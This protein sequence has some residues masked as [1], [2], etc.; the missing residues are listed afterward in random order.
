[1]SVIS[2]KDTLALLPTGGGKSICFQVPGLYFE[3]LTIVISP[4]ISLMED[5]VFNLKKKGIKA[6][7]IHSGMPKSEVSNVLDSCEFGGIKFLY[8]S[9]ERLLSKDFIEKSDQF[10]IDLIAIDESHCISQWGYDFRPSYL[11]ISEFIKRHPNAS[12]IA[13]TATAKPKVVE[14]IQEKLEF[15][16]GNVFRSS[17]ERKNLSYNT[18]SVKNKDNVLQSTLNKYLGSSIVYC[19]SRKEV[20]RVCKFLQLLG[21]SADF[22]HGGLNSFKRKEKQEKWIKDEIRIM[23]AT[24]AF[25]MGIDKPDVRLVFHY[26][27]PENIENYFQ[28]AGRGGRDLKE[29]IAV[30]AYQQSD[31]DTLGDRIKSKFLEE[32]QIRK[33]YDS[34]FQNAQIAVGTGK[35]ERIEFDIIKFS[36]KYE[37]DVLKTYNALKALENCGYLKYNLND[38]SNSQI[39]IL[40]DNETLYQFQITNPNY[41]AFLRYLVRSYPGIKDHSV[42]FQLENFAKHLKTSPKRIMEQLEFL[43]KHEIIDYSLRKEQPTITILQDRVETN[44]LKL[45]NH[46]FLKDNALQ[47]LD[48][49]LKFIK[50]KSCRSVFLGRYFGDEDVEECGKCSYCKSKSKSESESEEGVLGMIGE[51]IEFQELLVI[52]EL[53]EDDL[54]SI[55][56]YLMDEGKIKRDPDQFNYLIPRG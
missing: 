39:R 26:D 1:M 29:S 16:N 4:L 15:K 28:E 51:G 38:D 24:N 12:K 11:K 10:K 3:G 17:F 5:Q 33:I 35:E 36:K 25:G 13:L 50:N 23:V 52:S 43:Y 14:D 2:G 40:V 48:D 6:A 45:E 47:N 37:S 30:L 44:K 22:Y 54:I 31:I 46:R 7:F 21:Y 56:N 34:I 19:Y 9:P 8:I 27:I 53:S 32:N 20:K 18:V 55:L 41:D 49:V 42:V